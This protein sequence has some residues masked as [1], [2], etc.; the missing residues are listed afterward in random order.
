M[1][2][3]MFLATMV[4]P[5]TALDCG[6]VT[7]P[8]KVAFVVWARRLE[9]NNRTPA[10]NRRVDIDS[11][12]GMQLSFGPRFQFPRQTRYVAR[13]GWR[14]SQVSIWCQIDSIIAN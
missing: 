7:P 9:V 4:A 3:A 2:V 13:I 14:V 6:S 11:F 10:A 12:R 8:T 1:P 5:T